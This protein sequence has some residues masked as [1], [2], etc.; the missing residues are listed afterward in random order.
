MTLHIAAIHWTSFRDLHKPWRTLNT[1][2]KNLHPLGSGRIGGLKSHMSF[3]A[4]WIYILLFCLAS[5]LSLNTYYAS[6]QKVPLLLCMSSSLSKNQ[7]PFSKGFMSCVRPSSGIDGYLYPSKIIDICDEPLNVNFVKDESS[8]TWN[9][10]SIGEN[11]RLRH[12]IFG[13]TM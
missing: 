13:Y 3:D 12:C 10:I 1:Y 4:G 11:K 2:F 8:T 9:R 7:N 6:V 5:P